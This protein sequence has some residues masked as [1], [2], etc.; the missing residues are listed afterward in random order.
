MRVTP[1]ILIS[2]KPGYALDGNAIPLPT[3]CFGVD[4]GARHEVIRD[5]VVSQ[6]DLLSYGVGSSRSNLG[7]PASACEFMNAMQR[8]FCG[9]ATISPTNRLRVRRKT[10]GR[11]A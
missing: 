1:N 9:R 2:G 8:I 11:G 4:L 10:H 5:G 7:W 6:I 3:E